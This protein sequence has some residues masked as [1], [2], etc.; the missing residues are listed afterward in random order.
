V[1]YDYAD[2]VED[3]FWCFSAALAEGLLIVETGGI[4]SLSPFILLSV[5]F[6]FLKELLEYNSSVGVGEA[7]SVELLLNTPVVLD[8]VLI[9]GIGIA[10]G[11]T[12]LRFSSIEELR[13]L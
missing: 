3:S 11:A 10:I 2:H 8:V 13:E 1:V 12:L 5:C 6:W 7:R 9:L 4:D